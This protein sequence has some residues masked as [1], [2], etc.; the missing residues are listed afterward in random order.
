[1][2]FSDPKT[3]W[4]QAAG[5]G[6][7]SSQSSCPLIVPHPEEKGGWGSRK[8][9]DQW[10]PGDPGAQDW[11]LRGQRWAC[12]G[13]W[14]WGQSSHLLCLAQGR[15]HSHPGIPNPDSIS[16]HQPLGRDPQDPDGGSEL[17]SGVWPR[18]VPGDGPFGSLWAGPVRKGFLVNAL[19]VPL[20]SSASWV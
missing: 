15:E 1:M 20:P 4:K 16:E 5:W 10:G 17:R 8:L 19:H 18:R 6:L 2:D 12:A 14:G 7:G 9:W 13:L 3:T 11:S